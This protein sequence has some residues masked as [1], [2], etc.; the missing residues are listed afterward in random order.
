MKKA[1]A[2]SSAERMRLAC[3][4]MVPSPMRRLRRMMRLI[5]HLGSQCFLDDGVSSLVSAGQIRCTADK[6]A[7]FRPAFSPSL[8]RSTEE[9]AFQADDVLNLRVLLQLHPEA[10]FVEVG[11]KLFWEEE[12]RAGS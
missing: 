5:V 8:A 1:R 9:Q 3:E 12:A 10:V 4:V 7:W 6:K 2:Y 11:Q